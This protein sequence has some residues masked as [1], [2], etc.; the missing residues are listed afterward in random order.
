MRAALRR[1]SCS[2]SSM[3]TSAA[4]QA[5]GLPPKVEACA[6]GPQRIRSARATVA[7]NG[8]PLAMPLATVMISGVSWKWS[9]A[10]ILPVRP[11]PDCTSSQTSRMPCLSAS[12]MST[13]N[14]TSLRAIRIFS[15]TV[16]LQR[17]AGDHRIEHRVAALWHDINVWWAGRREHA[18]PEVLRG[19]NEQIPHAGPEIDEGGV[20][21]VVAGQQSL[22]REPETVVAPQD[23]LQ[24][25]TVDGQVATRT[26]E[27][28]EWLHGE[29]VEGV[30][31][32][33]G[34]SHTMTAEDDHLLEFR[35]IDGLSR[36]KGNGEE[37]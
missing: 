18:D 31:R 20:G 8:S 11:M 19:V 13:P 29:G 5:T 9:E 25:G 22:V 27:H 28:R 2:S 16:M 3:V 33:N 36:E 15:G 35:I 12:R 7:P 17:D 32:H 1:N 6:P 10:H 34:R 37:S 24:R 26:A 4:A 14:S 30:V 23:G 21:R